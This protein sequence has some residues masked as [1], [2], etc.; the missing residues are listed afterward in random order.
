M[1]MDEAQRRH[2]LAAMGIQLWLPRTVASPLGE[3]ALTSPGTAGA[4]V[5]AQVAA[6]APEAERGGRPTWQALRQQVSSC[7]ACRLHETR[8][9]AVF[10]VGDPQ[11]QW[12]VIGEAPGAEEDLQGEPF[13]GRA[14]KLLNEMLFAVGLQRQQVYIANIVKCRPP[15]NRE[16]QPDEATACAR[17]LRAQ[18]ELIQPQLILCVGRV[19]AVNLLGS[20]PSLAAYRGQTHRYADTQIP[21]VVTYHPAYLLR[22]PADK[23]K[24]WQ[25]LQFAV[26]VCRPGT[27]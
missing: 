7:T 2:Y 9:Q 8:S 17:Y 12:L 14:G 15:N 18:I 13:V 1:T 24:A 21:V 19:A 27:P 25:D 11:A 5:P 6:P 22:N 26:S 4:A 16:P 10:G 23:R 20:F 3:I